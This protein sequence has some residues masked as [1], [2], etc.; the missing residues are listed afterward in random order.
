MSVQRAIASDLYGMVDRATMSRN[1]ELIRGL[2]QHIHNSMQDGAVPAYVATPLIEQLSQSLEKTKQQTTGQSSAQQKPSIL[3][4]TIAHAQQ[5]QQGVDNL[6]SNMPQEYA[7]GGIIAFA[8]RGLVDETDEDDDDVDDSRYELDDRSPS[9]MQ[10]MNQIM[11]NRLRSIPHSDEAMDDSAMSRAIMEN[12]T[13]PEQPRNAKVARTALTPLPQQ[14]QGSPQPQPQ[15]SPQPQPQGSPQP[16]QMQSAPSYVSDEGRDQRMYSSRGTGAA[17]NNN[18]ENGLR[19]VQRTQSAPQPQQMQSAPQPQYEMPATAAFTPQNP[20]AATETPKGIAQ[21]YSKFVTKFRHEGGKEHKYEKQVIEEAKRQG[22]DPTLALHILYKETGGVKGDPALAMSEAKAKGVMQLMPATAKELGV[23]DVYDPTQNIH[24]GIKYLKQLSKMFK[25]DPTLI[26][27][28]YNGGMGNVIKY[29]GVPPFAQTEDYVQGLQSFAKGGTVKHFAGEGTSLV[30]RPNWTYGNGTY[31]S[32]SLPPS[33]PPSPAPLPGTAVAVQPSV[34]NAPPN[35]PPAFDPEYERLRGVR[36][37]AQRYAPS[38]LGGANALSRI[39]SILSKPIFGGI[40]ALLNSENAGKDSGI[41]RRV[42][43]TDLS[44][45]GP[46]TGE[47]INTNPNADK[48]KAKIAATFEPLGEQ[49]DAVKKEIATLESQWKGVSNPEQSKKI[50]TELAALR[51]KESDIRYNYGL[52]TRANEIDRPAQT[53]PNGKVIPNSVVKQ[54]IQKAIPPELRAKAQASTPLLNKGEGYGIQFPE[55]GDAY[56]DDPVPRTPEDKVIANKATSEN[57]STSGFKSYLDKMIADAD[58]NKNEDKWLALLAGGLGVMGG[59]SPH[60]FANIGQGGMQGIASLLASKKNQGLEQ[61]NIMYNLRTH[62][63]KEAQNKL[64]EQAN[65]E[66]VR[67]HT[68][69][70]SGLRNR[71]LDLK[72]IAA[73]AQNTSREKITAHINELI[74]KD[75][76]LRMLR[77]IIG[78]EEDP[79]K[80]AKLLKTY[81]DQIKIIRDSFVTGEPTTTKNTG[82][83]KQ[84]L[85]A[86]EGT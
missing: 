33:P 28:A 8:N 61:R 47:V 79:N 3:Q 30:T 12:S 27:A 72:N 34:I 71:Y 25:G 48:T 16:Q 31:S 37:A 55:G 52:S 74:L 4:Q 57:D 82:P 10:Q 43:P 75:D 11:L 84:T 73:G 38:I 5:A 56:I 2:Q 19:E 13:Q 76:G 60:A 18:Q 17:L 46:A 39:G 83:R 36:A 42:T 44:G 22:V 1:P 40:G 41:I 29:G 15:G 69:R 81:N 51:K 78:R 35:I 32:S 59:T 6:H 53:G 24:G 62:E 23:K 64:R 65:E 9:K 7:G 26:A 21:L 20:L 58:K 14:P 49:L 67:S 86:F 66:L 63:E 50:Q 80:K 77:Q 85:D 70:E 45:R 68:E 54:E